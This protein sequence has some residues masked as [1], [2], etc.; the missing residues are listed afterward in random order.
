[1][2][3]GKASYSLGYRRRGLDGVVL[4]VVGGGGVGV[5][6]LRRGGALLAPGRGGQVVGC[7]RQAQP[8]LGGLDEAV[9]GVPHGGFHFSLPL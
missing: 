6:V 1:M 4:V 9:G 3:S 2:I 8:E 5:V 7:P